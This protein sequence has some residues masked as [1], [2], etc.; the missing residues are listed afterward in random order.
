MKSLKAHGFVIERDTQDEVCAV[1]YFEVG[2]D[3]M[4][5][6]GLGLLPYPHGAAVHLSQA[7]T[8]AHYQH[9]IVAHPP[10]GPVIAFTQGECDWET[11]FTSLAG[12]LITKTLE[13]GGAVEIDADE[14]EL[15]EFM[16][17]LHRTM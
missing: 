16:R 12:A 6:A 4:V 13:M 3:D 14:M 7:L 5:L 9:R 10:K 11:L 1:H 2:E 15:D 8:A 17:K